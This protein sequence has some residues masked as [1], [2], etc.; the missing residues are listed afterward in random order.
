MNTEATPIRECDSALDYLYSMLDGEAKKRFEA[1]L[2]TCARCQAELEAFGR[3]RVVA[4]TAL[5]TAEPSER[6]TGALHAQLMHAASQRKPR[7]QVGKIVPFMRRMLS[8]PG[9]TAAAGILII[10]GAV[11]IQFSRGHV[12]MPAPAAQESAAPQGASPVTVASPPPVAAAAPAVPADAPAAGEI[13][14][15][16]PGKGGGGTFAD[17][18]EAAADTKKIVAKPTE[19]GKLANL[20]ELDEV[21]SSAAPTPKLAKAG[22]ST[23]D[24]G[25]DLAGSRA[26]TARL[27]NDDSARGGDVAE[28]Q[29]P[30]KDGASVGSM[31]GG[32][33]GAVSGAKGNAQPTKPAAT[34]GYG[35]NSYG[36]RS[37]SANTTPAPASPVAK[38]APPRQAAAPSATVAP[39][40]PPIVQ[41]PAAGKKQA[42][43]RTLNDDLY[44]AK[45]A[46]PSRREEPRQRPLEEP[47]VA[48]NHAYKA[49]SSAS[50]GS[51]DRRAQSDADDS[52]AS[53]E[54]SPAAVASPE[55]N[56]ARSEDEAPR[57]E[58]ADTNSQRADVTQRATDGVDAERKRA[59]T[60][61]QQ[62][63]CAE[64]SV[65]FESLEKR[66]PERLSSTD[67]ITYERCL[68]TLGR[69]EPA[70]N[71]L[72]QLRNNRSQQGAYPAAALNAEQKALDVQRK[73]AAE[74][75]TS[76]ELRRAAKAKSKV[77]AAD[78]PAAPAD[79]KNAETNVKKVFE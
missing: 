68:R 16:L 3:V 18:R 64:A 8:H 75:S 37:E 52:L 32:L 65:V 71:E 38:S 24:E 69:L 51:R 41:A 7:G 19:D 9:Y 76:N 34:T 12:M 22:P 2:A 25:G 33:V 59:S 66:T 46:P 36:A 50:N 72:D 73:R 53:A 4:Q 6:L 43:G 35:A 15:E 58:K 14:L 79:S 13:G 63:R 11:G 20:K 61:A 57:E 5:S 39:A 40:P 62:G 48:A 30:A 45:P 56:K 10:G 17:K 77:R 55:P 60:L 67:R 49:P 28:K 42:A 47:S 31:T 29:L 1:H 70:Q 26:I 21:K 54:R 23:R 27:K 74:S 44:D 78:A